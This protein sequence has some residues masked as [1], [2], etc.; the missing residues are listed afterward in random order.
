MRDVLGR[1]QKGNKETLENKQIRI[2]AILLANNLNPNCLAKLKRENPYI[3]NSWR[4][5][6][7]TKKGKSIGFDATWSDFNIFYNDVNITYKK[8]LRL[9]RINKSESFGPNNFVWVTDEQSSILKN[10]NI[11]IEYNNETLTIYEWALKLNVSVSAI[12]N[13]YYK[14]NNYT[15]EEILLGKK[16]EL[17]RKS[18]DIRDLSSLQYQKDKASKMIAAYRCKDRNKRLNCDL[19]VPWFID[20]I[21]LQSCFYCGTNKYVGADRIN[22][23]LGHTKDNII[24]CCYICNT[25]RNNNFSVEEMKLIG[26]TIKTININR[27]DNR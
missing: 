25:T 21:L 6:L 8:G 9:N 13:R 11:L 19:D 27:E 26:E 15:S 2:N 16:K 22:N 17:K 24:P 7:Y 1:F 10:N 18:I 3:F 4:S 12:K 23:N 5:I 20:N 14:H